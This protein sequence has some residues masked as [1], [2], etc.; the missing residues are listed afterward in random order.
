VIRQA[1][2][3]APR[4]GNSHLFVE[5][6]A[7]SEHSQSTYQEPRLNRIRVSIDDAAPILN[8]TS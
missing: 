2:Q 3:F 7:V 1:Q 6:F 8:N 5:A 4:H